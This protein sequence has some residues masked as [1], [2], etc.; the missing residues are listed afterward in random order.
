[1][2]CAV[3]SYLTNR[4]S[5]SYVQIRAGSSN[6][7]FGGSL[8]QATHIIKHE[9]YYYDYNDYDVAVVRVSDNVL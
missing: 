8:H 5:A 2:Y 9:R 6:L 7:G 3:A 1:M 4:I